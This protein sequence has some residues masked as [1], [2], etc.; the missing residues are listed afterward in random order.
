M[1]VKIFSFLIISFFFTH[2]GPQTV[3]L[4]CGCFRETSRD[5]NAFVE[6]RGSS[7]DGRSGIGGSSDVYEYLK[8]LSYNRDIE[9]LCAEY[10]SRGEK[11]AFCTSDTG[12]LRDIEDEFPE[13]SVY[14][15]SSQS[16]R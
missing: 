15:E 13:V 5:F 14:D 16:R 4:E 3:N 6:T 10:S 1:A 9:G 8:E 2:C 7:S 12:V 11:F